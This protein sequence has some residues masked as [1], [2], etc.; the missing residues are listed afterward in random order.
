MSEHVAQ[1]TWL[2]T[3]VSAQRFSDCNPTHC[4]AQAAYDADGVLVAVPS[5][6][7]YEFLFASDFPAVDVPWLD[8]KLVACVEA[9]LLM[10]RV[11]WGV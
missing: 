5:G 6:W 10:W 2:W 8:V 1:R 4:A 3:S 11:S 9:P 7:R